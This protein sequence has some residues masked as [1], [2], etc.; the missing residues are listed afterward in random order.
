MTLR[1]EKLFIKYNDRIN[2]LLARTA[3]EKVST[4]EMI[5]VSAAG[6]LYSSILDNMDNGIEV[7]YELWLN[8]IEEFLKSPKVLEIDP[9]NNLL[10]MAN[11][12]MRCPELLKYYNTYFKYK[13]GSDVSQLREYVGRV[14]RFVNRV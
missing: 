3:K 1:T 14:E 11:K 5:V 4:L 7:T 8:W 12:I 2:F 6:K 9:D 13:L 10:N